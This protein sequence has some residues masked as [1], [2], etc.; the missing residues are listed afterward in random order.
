MFPARFDYLAPTSIAEAVGALRTLGDDAKVLAGG[1]SLI[2]L[3]KL[4]LA[5]PAYL[6]DIGRLDELGGVR[7]DDEGRLV[8]GALTT[9]RDLERSEL[10]RQRCPVVAEASATV[11]DPL[12]RSRATLGG[13]LA[14]ADPA[15]D[16]PAVMLAIDAELLA[17]GPDGERAIPADEFF[18]GM[19]E[20]S[21]AD[22]E[23][24]TAVR[25]PA[26][27]PGAGCVYVK[28]EQQAGDFATA[29][30]AAWVLVEDG[31]IADARVG[32]TNAGPV[33][34]RATAL[35]DRLRGERADAGTAERVGRTVAGDIEPSDSLRGSAGYRRQMVTIAVETAL[36]AAVAR[37]AGRAP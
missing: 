3:M 9:E 33:P 1:Q 17:R 14:H 22:D 16:H 4:R 8:I 34:A 24:L 32:L 20:T 27:P 31:V 35:E 12:V 36:S 2:P 28:K 13:N 21:L 11:A 29:G 10:V 37:A 7:V 25:I 23:L 30:A 5:T 18:V 26:A 6:V 19:F 15:N